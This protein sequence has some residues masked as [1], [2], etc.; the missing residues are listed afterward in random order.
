MFYQENNSSG[1][2]HAK[3]EVGQNFSFPLHFH[4][5]FEFITVTDGEMTVWVDKSNY[6]VTPSNAL[7]IFPNQAHSL[8]TNSYSVHILCI[9][10]SRTVKAF[11]N[12]SNGMLPKSALFFPNRYYVD[13]LFDLISSKSLTKEKGVLYSLCAEFEKDV[14]YVQC[15]IE[16]DDLLKQIFRFVENNFDK[17]CSLSALSKYTTYNDMYVSRYFKQHTGITYID[18]VNTYRINMAVYLINNSDKNMSNIAFDCGFSSIR[19]FNRKFKE[20]MGITP[21]E[22]RRE[23]TIDHHK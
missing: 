21:N 8:Q 19:H 4:D 12:S 7:L 18:H 6:T 5:S 10:P 11:A 20:I 17:D 22:F 13:Q 23:N 1:V 3:I 16:N 2:E 15:P 14:E 9:F